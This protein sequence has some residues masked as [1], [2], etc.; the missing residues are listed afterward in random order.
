MS[1][2]VVAGGLFIYLFIYFR[3]D[4]TH[5]VVFPTLVLKVGSKM[6]FHPTENKVRS[7]TALD[8]AAEV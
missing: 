3:N 6:F 4:S 5:A 2:P 8:F 1:P 7:L